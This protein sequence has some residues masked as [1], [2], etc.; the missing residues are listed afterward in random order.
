MEHILLG[1]LG[2]KDGGAWRVLNAFGVEPARTRQEILKE[3][4]PNFGQ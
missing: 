4:D 1:L 3:L 2:E